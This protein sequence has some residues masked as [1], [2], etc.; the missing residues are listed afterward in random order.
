MF[1]KTVE[2][3][4]Q[5]LRG[6]VEDQMS[7]KRLEDISPTL[8]LCVKD[9]VNRAKYILDAVKFLGTPGIHPDAL[10]FINAAFYTAVRSYNHIQLSVCQLDALNPKDSPLKNPQMDESYMEILNSVVAS[11]Q[12]CVKL[13]ESAEQRMHGLLYSQPNF[14]VP[15]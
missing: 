1:I 4:E 12:S 15:T 2:E 5:K 3:M 7:Q 14:V 8:Y 6:M 10:T 9:C 13:C 11:A